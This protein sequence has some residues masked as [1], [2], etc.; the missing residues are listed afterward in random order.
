MHQS[1]YYFK[2]C[3][4]LFLKATHK[5]LYNALVKLGFFFPPGTHQYKNVIIRHVHFIILLTSTF[6][7]EAQFLIYFYFL[8]DVPAK[9]SLSFLTCG[10]D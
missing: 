7:F 1:S 4:M 8:Q 3:V 2:L 9:I 5:D 10:G 6:I